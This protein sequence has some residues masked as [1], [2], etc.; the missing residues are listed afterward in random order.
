MMRMDPIPPLPFNLVVDVF[1][2]ML[3]KAANQGILGGLLANMCE[4]DIVSL[5]YR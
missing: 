3:S 1:T 4:D 2:K 5:Q